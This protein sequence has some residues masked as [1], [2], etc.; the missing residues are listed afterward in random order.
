MEK[1]ILKNSLNFID[2]SFYYIV[3][4]CLDGMSAVYILKTKHQDIKH[5]S[6]SLSL[7]YTK[8]WEIFF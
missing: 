2:K 8:F 6:F 5:L 7:I 1:Y 4:Y 3:P